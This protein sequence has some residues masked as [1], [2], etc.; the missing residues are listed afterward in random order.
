MFIAFSCCSLTVDPIQIWWLWSALAPPAGR[1][2]ILLSG[3]LPNTE[4]PPG[5]HAVGRETLSWTVASSG[6]PSPYACRAEHIYKS[7]IILSDSFLDIS[8]IIS[9]FRCSN[10]YIKQYSIKYWSVC[11]CHRVNL[12]YLTSQTISYL[13]VT[14]ARI[15][16]ICVHLILVQFY[17]SNGLHRRCWASVILLRSHQIACGFLSVSHQSEQKSLQP[18]GQTSVHRW[19]CFITW[20]RP[21]E[22]S[23]IQRWECVLVVF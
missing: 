11:E 9:D 4:S 18:F 8:C 12:V 15:V 14:S 13:T 1:S 23:H 20:A 10:N 16:W 17:L 3:V 6:A 5:G 21:P 19:E 22:Q 2:H 7:Q